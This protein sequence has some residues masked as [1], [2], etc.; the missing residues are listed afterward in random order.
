M[1]FKTYKHCV[2]FKKLKILIVQ[3]VAKDNF[4]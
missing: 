4:V 2:T 1:L 3:I